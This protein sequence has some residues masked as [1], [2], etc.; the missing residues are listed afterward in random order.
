MVLEE[1]KKLIVEISDLYGG[2]LP[3]DIQSL[4]D[5]TTIEELIIKADDLS[6]LMDEAAIQYARVLYR[7]GN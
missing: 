5:F 7:M 2:A 3:Y 4:E 1:A 6:K